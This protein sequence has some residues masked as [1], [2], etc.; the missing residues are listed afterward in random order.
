MSLK[1]HTV[2]KSLIPLTEDA[3]RPFGDI[4]IRPPLSD[5]Y[6]TAPAWSYD[7]LLGLQR[8]ECGALIVPWIQAQCCLVRVQRPFVAERLK[9][10]VEVVAAFRLGHCEFKGTATSRFGV[11]SDQSNCCI[12]SP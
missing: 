1:A 8:A 6:G 11:N 4:E 5:L 10:A 7:Y 2:T 9:V 3:L 12:A